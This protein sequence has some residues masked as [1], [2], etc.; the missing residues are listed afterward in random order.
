MPPPPPSLVVAA[1]RAWV[2]LWAVV[3]AHD[4]P[5]SP[6]VQRE[7]VSMV[8]LTVAA[9]AIPLLVPVP[10]PPLPHYPPA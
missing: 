1:A 3:A 2:V 8:D 7:A 10:V 9:A 4:P 6:A 5:L